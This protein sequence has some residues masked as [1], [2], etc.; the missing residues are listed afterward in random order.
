LKIF[1]LHTRDR[2]ASDDNYYLILITV[3]AFFPTNEQMVYDT[4]E[5]LKLK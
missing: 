4:A 2:R 3:V 5:D 1:T